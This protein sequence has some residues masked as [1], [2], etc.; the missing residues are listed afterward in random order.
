MESIIYGDQTLAKAARK[1]ADSSTYLHSDS[2]EINT[3][4]L[5]GNESVLGFQLRETFLP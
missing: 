3:G 5:Q 1:S 4:K 2:L